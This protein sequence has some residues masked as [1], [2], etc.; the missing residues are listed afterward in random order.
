MD[1]KEVP[2]RLGWKFLSMSPKTVDDTSYKELKKILCEALK[3]YKQ[4][5]VGSKRT[6]VTKIECI[7][8][9]GGIQ[10]HL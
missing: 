1:P 8:F 3:V 5:G 10:W 9:E 2:F 4:F 7:D 6:P